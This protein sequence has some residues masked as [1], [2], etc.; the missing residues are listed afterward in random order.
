[1]RRY[2]QNLQP[3]KDQSQELIQKFYKSTRGKQPNRK[4][5]KRLKQN[6]KCTWANRHTEILISV[7]QRNKNQDYSDMFNWQKLSPTKSSF[8]KSFN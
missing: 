7:N 6:W 2:L 8:G 4:M 3:V 5:G 1:M